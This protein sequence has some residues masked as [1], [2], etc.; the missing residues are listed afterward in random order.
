MLS[1]SLLTSWQPTVALSLEHPSK[2]LTA[3]TN[4]SRIGKWCPLYA[5]ISTSLH[6]RS[7]VIDPRLY[8]KFHNARRFF[9]IGQTLQWGQ[10]NVSQSFHFG[11]VTIRRI[12]SRSLSTCETRERSNTLKLSTDETAFWRKKTSSRR[13]ARSL[14]LCS[15]KRARSWPWLHAITKTSSVS[16]V[17]SSFSKRAENWVTLALKSLINVTLRVSPFRFW[18]LTVM[19][20]SVSQI[21]GSSNEISDH[22]WRRWKLLPS[23]ATPASSTFTGVSSFNNSTIWGT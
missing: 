9:W 12:I 22:T 20:L 18:T 4:K 15:L 5:A 2:A 10:C 16:V 11:W 8:V 21:S 23:P 6:K 7:V 19:S 3:S 17:F 13:S 1:T 14:R